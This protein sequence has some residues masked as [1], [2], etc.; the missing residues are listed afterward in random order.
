MTLLLLLLLIL[1][2]CGRGAE[3][4]P[5]ATRTDSAGVEVVVNAAPL[6]SAGDGWRIDLVPTPQIGHRTDRDSLYDLLRI[7][8]GAVLR[9]GE[10]IALV[11][12]NRQARLFA[13]SGEWLRNIGRDGAGPGELRRVSAMSLSGDTLF[14]PDGELRRLNAFRLTG[15]FLK[16]WPYFAAEGIGNLPPSHRLVDGSWIA[17]AGLPFGP[18]DISTEGM[19]RQRI[20]YYRVDAEMSALLDTIAE[21]QGRELAVTRTGGADDLRGMVETAVPAPLGRFSAVAVAADRFAWGDNSTPEVRFHAADGSMRRIVRWSAPATSVD[22]ALLDRLKQEALARAEGN[23]AARQSIEA[24]YS[25]ASPA[26]VV[27]YFEDLRI[28]AAG[29]LWVQEY[30]LSAADSVHFRIFRSDGQ[31]LGRRTL[32]PRHRMLDIGHDRLLTV[33]QDEDDLEYLRVYRVARTP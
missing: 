28:D 10:I 6:W 16:A 29:A 2:A 33:W 3:P 14:I 21:A 17:S 26:P 8:A 4:A 32:P 5:L 7:S 13:P 20:R 31:Y 12:A 19:L 24:Q 25:R 30:L 23:E 15:E 9:S 1:A 27:P 22:G 11:G 18:D